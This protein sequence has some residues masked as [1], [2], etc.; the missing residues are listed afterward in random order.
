MRTALFALAFLTTTALACG[1]GDDEASTQGASGSGGSSSGASGASSGKG[2]ASAGSAGAS[3]GAG[4]SSAGQGGS[5]AGAG[6]STAGSGGTSAGSSGSTAGQG[7]SSAGAGGSVAGA[8]GSSAGKAGAAGGG[9]VRAQKPADRDRFVVVGHPSGFAPGQK[10]IDWE[11]LALSKTGTLSRPNT[12][13]SMGVPADARV[14]FSPDGEIGYALQDDGTIGIFQLSETGAPTV[15]EPGWKGAFSYASSFVLSADG[16]KAWVANENWPD[17]GGGVYA[18]DVLCDGRLADAGLVVKTKNAWKGPVLLD[19]GDAVV[20]SRETQGAP[21]GQSIVRTTLGVPGMVTGSVDAFGDDKAIIAATAKTRDGKVVIFGDDNAFDATERLA[22]VGVD[23][24]GV[25]KLQ[26][27]PGFPAIASIATSPFDDLVVVAMWESSSYAVLSYTPGAAQPLAS[28]GTK[29]GPQVPGAI[30]MVERG[31]LD[32][33]VMIGEVRG[34]YQL[35]FEKGAV[36][37]L[38]V[39]DLGKGTE[40]I[41]GGVGVQP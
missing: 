29:K 17:A 34:L 11:V 21:A 20:F 24:A 30:A 38:G 37:D 7:G 13:F 36:K 18:L 35:Q 14:T 32:G 5:S 9:C 10:A 2:G 19:G 41:V 8:G 4:G 25:T 3:A 28:M 31:P 6:G 33:R 26:L 40:N 16:T 1:G 12:H 22:V 15:L 27:L 39:Y 23:G